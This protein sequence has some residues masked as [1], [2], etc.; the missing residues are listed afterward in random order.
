M[1]I[2][3]NK[4]VCKTADTAAGLVCSMES[5]EYPQEVCVT[6]KRNQ[7][8]CRHRASIARISLFVSAQPQGVS[9]AAAAA[10]AATTTKAAEAATARSENN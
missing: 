8:Q 10:A 7:T 5:V 6:F 3:E 1:R 9:A 4:H 2:L